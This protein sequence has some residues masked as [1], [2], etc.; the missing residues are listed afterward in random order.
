[1]TILIVEAEML[2]VVSLTSAR[3]NLIPIGQFD[4]FGIVFVLGSQN[5]ASES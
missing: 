2:T 5:Q 4:L 3:P 1:M